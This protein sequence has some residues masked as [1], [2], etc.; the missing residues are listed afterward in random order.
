MSSDHASPLL[1]GLVGGFSRAITAIYSPS[2]EGTFAT[3]E[4][5]LFVDRSAAGPTSLHRPERTGRGED[6][7]AESVLRLVSDE[8]DTPICSVRCGTIGGRCAE[9]QYNGDPP[10][11]WQT[12]RVG[13]RAP[14]V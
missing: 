7:P 8:S 4:D 6:E 3:M 2:A 11:G 5:G 13:R 14:A 9:E 12:A 10:R 1:H